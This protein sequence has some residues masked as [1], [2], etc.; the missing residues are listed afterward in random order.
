MGEHTELLNRLPGP[1]PVQVAMQNSVSETRVRG[2]DVAERLPPEASPRLW[3]A[4]GAELRTA[5][6]TELARRAA[7]G[8]AAA[9]A[10]EL[11]SQACSTWGEIGSSGDDMT[12]PG[13]P[14]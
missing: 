9:A 7:P 11:R 10:A 8:A 6:T 3:E 1:L 5:V 14:P 13:K 2:P 12:P 4:L